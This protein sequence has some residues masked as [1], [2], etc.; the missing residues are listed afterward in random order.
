MTIAAPSGETEEQWSQG[1]LA[2]IGAP[3]T[4]N[5]ED[6]ILQWMTAEEP[7]DNWFDRNNPLNASLGTSSTSGLGS[8][9]NL[10]VADQETADMIEQTNMSGIANA[11]RSNASPD[12]FSAAVVG[13]PWASSHYGGN[14][15]AIAN[16][17]T[18]GGTVTAPSGA[19]LDSVTGDIGSA[20]GG[21]AGGATADAVESLFGINGGA[22]LATR[23]LLGVVALIFLAIGLDKLF[24]SSASPSDIVVQAPQSVSNQA[25]KA[26]TFAS[27]GRGQGRRPPMGKE[28]KQEKQPQG[29][30]KGTPFQRGKHVAGKGAEKIAET[31]AA[32]AVA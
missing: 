6:N 16:I 2:D 18:P 32:A 23:I 8:Y 24:D 17:P 20:I 14:P 5:N 7:T 25:G 10:Q 31:G 21:A 4:V 29:K 12:A 11:L 27:K 19:Q 26:Q 15:D 9:P 1:L 22:G 30:A 28:H 13:S 3:D